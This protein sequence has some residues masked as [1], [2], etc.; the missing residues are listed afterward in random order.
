[1]VVCSPVGKLCNRLVE[2]KPARSARTARTT[3]LRVNVA[4]L[5]NTTPPTP[6]ASRAM[7]PTTQMREGEDA[8]A[9]CQTCS[10][11]CA[12]RVVCRSGAGFKPAL[13][14]AAAGNSERGE[15]GGRRR[16]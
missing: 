13:Q 3:M 8:T 11:V 9:V 15:V 16:T 1:M 7:R 10:P 5:S 6:R 12:A 2:M 4:L 14:E